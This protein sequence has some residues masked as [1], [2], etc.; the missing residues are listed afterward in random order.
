M[1][2]LSR[3][4]SQV[5]EDYKVY[6]YLQNNADGVFEG[7]GEI[8]IEATSEKS[9]DSVMKKLF[10]FGVFYK[11]CGCCGPRW[12]PANSYTEVKGKTLRLLVAE[13]SIEYPKVPGSNGHTFF[14][15]RTGLIHVETKNPAD[16][17][18]YADCLN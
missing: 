12:E 6:R 18:I 7:P 16:K 11:G 8:Y 3:I 1:S 2:I 15:D 13:Y 10:G 5:P 9:A 17:H 14:I 4:F